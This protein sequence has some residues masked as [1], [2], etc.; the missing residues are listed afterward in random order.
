MHMCMLYTH[1]QTQ[2]HR[3]WP[4]VSN[5]G[6]VLAPSG[7]YSNCLWYRARKETDREPKA[8]RG[9]S[10]RRLHVSF[11]YTSHSLKGRRIKWNTACGK[12][13]SC[14]NST[15]SSPHQNTQRWIHRRDDLNMTPNSH[16]P[17]RT[18]MLL[19]HYSERKWAA[20]QRLTVDSGNSAQVKLVF[21]FFSRWSKQ[22]YYY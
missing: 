5:S 16:N 21:F 15:Y 3:C 13:W 8:A 1:T 11:C 9:R 17:Q 22:D 14:L 10:E 6:S 12:G 18:Q 19:L 20:Q 7:S 4:L 2:T